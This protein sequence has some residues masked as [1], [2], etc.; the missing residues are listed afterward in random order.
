MVSEIQTTQD[1]WPVLN[2]VVFVPLIEKNK[3]FCFLLFDITGQVP[4]LFL[5][6]D[7]NQREYTCK[8][9]IRAYNALVNTYGRRSKQPGA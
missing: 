7:Q 1:I 9:A 2:S 8:Q 3:S 6:G 4:K 5:C